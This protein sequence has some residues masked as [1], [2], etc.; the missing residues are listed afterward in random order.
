LRIRACEARPATAKCGGEK[1]HKGACADCSFLE[2]CRLRS[3]G[4]AISRRSFAN[5]LKAFYMAFHYI[6][7]DWL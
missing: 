1:L 5:H 3:G 2:P 7:H 4:A 6:N